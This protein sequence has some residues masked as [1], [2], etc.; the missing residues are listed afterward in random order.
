MYS[1]AYWEGLG[2]SGVWST[3]HF[4]V[5]HTLSNVVGRG[6]SPCHALA[7]IISVDLSNK[8]HGIYSLSTESLLSYVERDACTINNEYSSNFYTL[9]EGG[10]SY[11]KKKK[12]QKENWAHKES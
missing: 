9:R 7:Y 6:K 2:R 1:V 10:K 5:C 12:K 4:R 3:L 8:Q 11:Q